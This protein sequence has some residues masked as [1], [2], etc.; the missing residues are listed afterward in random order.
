MERSKKNRIIRLDGVCFAYD[1]E[2]AIRYASME[3]FKGETIILE[4]ANGSG[5]STLIR[6]LNG[7]IFPEEGTYYF[8]NIEISPRTMKDQKTAKYFHQKV[9]YVFQNSDVQLFCAS[10][11]EE[12]AFGPL[13]MGL[14]DQ[15]VSERVDDI[16]KMMGLEHLRGRAPYHLSGGEKKKVAIACILSMNPEVLILDEPL[17]GL[18]RETQRWFMDLLKKMKQAGKTIIIATHNEKLAEKLGTRRFF[19]RED[20]TV[21]QMWDLC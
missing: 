14:S 13:Q 3:I 10:V 1:G 21:E 19:F 9:G 6:L 11:E 15:E 8:E 5:K 12:I 16:I 4:G 20:H 17:A 7:L 2:I 18:D